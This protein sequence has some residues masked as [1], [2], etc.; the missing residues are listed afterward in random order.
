MH[1]EG[2]FFRRL[3]TCWRSVPSLAKR[4]GLGSVLAIWLQ[5]GH[6]SLV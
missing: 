2:F 6:W 5:G 3:F 1:N 4:L